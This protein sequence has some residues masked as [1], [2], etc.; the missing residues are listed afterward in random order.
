MGYGLG[1]AI[2]ATHSNTL[3]YGAWVGFLLGVTLIAT[4]KVLDVLYAGK[5]WTLFA[6]DTGYLLVVT[7]VM[8]AIL[9]TL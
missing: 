4:T 1:W 2:A 5:S 7:V 3:Y 9:G 8:G 6:I